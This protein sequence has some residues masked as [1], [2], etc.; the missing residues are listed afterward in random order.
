MKTPN[1][2]EVRYGKAYLRVSGIFAISVAALFFG[3]AGLIYMLI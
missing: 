3:A 1:K 2:F